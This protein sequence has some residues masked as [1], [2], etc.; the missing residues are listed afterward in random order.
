MKKKIATLI[1]IS[2]LAISP[3]LAKNA[4]SFA[5]DTHPAITQKIQF[6]SAP[7]LRQ[8]SHDRVNTRSNSRNRFNNRRSSNRNYNS[9]RY[10]RGQ[11]LPLQYRSHYAKDWHARGL[12]KA[13]AGYRWVY[14]NND[15]YLIAISSGIIASIALDVLR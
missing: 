2:G 12:H 8:T 9:D 5:K 14:R 11:V 6:K 1:A 15:A 7:S 4:V 13:P 10:S 3:A